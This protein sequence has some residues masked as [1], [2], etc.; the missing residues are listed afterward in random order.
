[1]Q[2]A[3]IGKDS[4]LMYPIYEANLIDETEPWHHESMKLGS[5]LMDLY[6][7]RTGPLVE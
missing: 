2:W 4:D 3:T 1:M 5:V 6:Q 7:E